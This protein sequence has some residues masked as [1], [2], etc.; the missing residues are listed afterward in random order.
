MPALQLEDT[1]TAE[2]PAEQNEPTVEMENTA[3]RIDR[4]KAKAS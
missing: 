1:V 4:R 3:G 2:M